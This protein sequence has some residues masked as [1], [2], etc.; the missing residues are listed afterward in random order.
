MNDY[1]LSDY[2][3]ILLKAF[4][5][6]IRI[7]EK[8][9][10]RYYCAGG[11]ML[12]AIRHNGFIPW[13]DDID[14]FM[15]RDDYDAFV[16]LKGS[17]NGY[18]VI[19]VSTSS[20]LATFAKFYDTNTTLW[21]LKQIPFVY[22]VYMD[23]FPLDETID[24]ITGFNK[25]YKR[26]RNKCRLYQLSQMRFSLSDLFHCLIKH[27]RVCFIK[28]LLSMFIPI[29]LSSFF[30]NR[31]QEY[32]KEL[33]RSSIGTHYASYYGDYWTKEFLERSWFDYYIEVPFES[34]SVR[35][36]NGYDGYLSQVYGDYMSLPPMNK[37]VSHHYHYYL[38]LK[39]RM[40]IEEII[41]ELLK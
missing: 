40:T 2:R 12:G 18:D 5:E 22:G 19:S 10:F 15:P 30:R 3:S 8:H 31:I 37:R 7:C 23:I 35:V 29:R 21:E 17:L 26:L 13:D 14:V 11:T 33:S 27:N 36:C 24:E 9:S 1:C 16:S 25:K 32:E 6:F 4:A 28:G 20:H 39:K 41:K 38:N 34:L